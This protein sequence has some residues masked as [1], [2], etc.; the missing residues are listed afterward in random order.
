[1][2]DKLLDIRKRVLKVGDKV[3]V[4]VKNYGYKE[5]KSAELITTTYEGKGQWGYKFGKR[6]PIYIK[7]P[8][9]VKL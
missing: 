3:A 2:E 7:H 4:V 9:C 1:M 5:I 8:Q 6:W